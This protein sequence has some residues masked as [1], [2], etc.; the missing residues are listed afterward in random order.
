MTRKTRISR[1]REFSDEARQEIINRDYGECIFC[2]MKYHMEDSTWF[3]QQIKGIM[4]Y[5]PRSSN[6]LGIPQNGAVGCQYHHEMLDNSNKGRRKEMLELFKKY[7]QKHYPE[8]NEIDLIYSKW[9]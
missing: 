6:G 1:V 4:H 8:W 5:I 3:G 7:L 9:R 2:R